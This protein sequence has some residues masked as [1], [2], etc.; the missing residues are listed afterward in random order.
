MQQQQVDDNTSLIGTRTLKVHMAP[1][2]RPREKAKRSGFA[3]LSIAELFAIIVGSGSPGESVVDLCQRILND[4]GGKL[5]N[6][7]RRGYKELMRNYKGIGE[8]KALE[9]EAALELARRYQIEKV[10]QRPQITSSDDAYRYLR[11]RMKDNTN[12]QLWV[13]FLNRSKHVLGLKC[14]SQGGTSATVGDVKMILK[15]AIEELADTIIIAHNHPSDNPT[16]SPQDDALTR[17]VAAGCQAVGIPLVDHIIVCQDRYYS[18]CD[19]N[20]L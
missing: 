20:R 11:M 10:E 7:A 8:V 16:P 9:L 17:K 15:A 2:D 6:I 5:Y 12:E 1:D 14:M 4:N 13:V 19:K 18:Y 3:A